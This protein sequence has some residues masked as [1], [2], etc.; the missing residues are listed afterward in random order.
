VK[1]ESEPIFL[2]DGHIW[3]SAGVTAGVD[4]ALA[5]VEEDL[6]R[7]ASLAIARQLVVYLKRPGG[8]SQF[9]AAL[10]LQ[11][12]NKRFE[13][14]NAWI[15]DNLGKDLSVPRLAAKAGMSERNFARRYREATG[16]TP[17]RAIERLRIEAAQR[18]LCETREPLKRVASQCGFGCEETMRRSFL[19]IAG[20]GPQDF[21]ARFSR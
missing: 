19:K 10:A 21:R 18:R 9:S 15:G 16:S 1:V 6:G 11:S 14:F 3:T 13:A 5:L 20:I 2:R 4:L 17:A 12:G 8:Q 7:R